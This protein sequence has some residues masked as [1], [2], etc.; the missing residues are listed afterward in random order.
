[1]YSV[2]WSVENTCSHPSM[3][4]KIVSWNLDSFITSDRKGRSCLNVP[5]MHAK[6]EK[7]LCVLL[8]AFIILGSWVAKAEVGKS[9]RAVLRCVL[10]MILVNYSNHIAQVMYLWNIPA[11]MAIELNLLT[12]NLARIP[13]ASHRSVSGIKIEYRHQHRRLQSL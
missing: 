5:W 7:S 9:F 4:Q 1:M 8:P 6:E 2:K 13:T 3:W 12:V 11:D 10:C